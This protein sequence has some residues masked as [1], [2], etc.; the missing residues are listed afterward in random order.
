VPTRKQFNVNLAPELVRRVKHQ[1]IDVSY[2][3]PTGSA[4]FW[5]TI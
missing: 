2:R 1:A 3:C 4:A 5:S